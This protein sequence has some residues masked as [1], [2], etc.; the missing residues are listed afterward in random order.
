MEEEG[1]TGASKIRAAALQCLDVVRLRAVFDGTD[2]LAMSAKEVLG[3]SFL[4]AVNLTVLRSS[5][6]A[7]E[8]VDL[9]LGQEASIWFCASVLFKKL[10]FEYLKAVL[11]RSFEIFLGTDK[12]K[13]PACRVSNNKMR[14]LDCSSS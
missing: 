4:L 5:V 7:E 11:P 6:E 13:F 10:V 9:P 1:S 8:R 2:F 3:N 14:A 12:S